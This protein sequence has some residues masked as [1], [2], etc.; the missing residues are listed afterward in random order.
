MIGNGSVIF[1]LENVTPEE[2]ERIRA[3]LKSLILCG[4][5]NIRNGS[6]T[7]HFDN[8]GQLQLIESNTIKYRR[9][10]Q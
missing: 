10:K 1:D 4:G 9:K 3:I 6:V 7:M 5:L 2:T 8:E